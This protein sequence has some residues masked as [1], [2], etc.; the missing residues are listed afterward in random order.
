MTWNI[1]GKKKIV[2]R[3]ANRLEH[4]KS[5]CKDSPTIEETALHAAIMQAIKDTYVNV[6]LAIETTEQNLARILSPDFSEDEFAIRSRLRE[7]KEQKSKLVQKY[8]EDG[9]DGRYDLQFNNVVN[10][11]VDLNQRLTGIEETAQN[12]KLSDSRMEEIRELLER[13]RE[14]DMEFDN[15]LVYRI[16]REI[17]VNTDREIE[18][19][20]HEGKTA[21]K[22]VG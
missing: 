1:R 8:L 16:I 22:K 9:D 6:K 10:E 19:V 21:K 17:R 3:C 13:F 7:L 20:F 12:K 15:D 18:I 2:W 11:I 14:T 4:G 5:I